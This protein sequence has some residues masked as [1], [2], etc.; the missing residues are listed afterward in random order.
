MDLKKLN[1]TQLLKIKKQVFNKILLDVISIGIT[2]GIFVY[3]MVS[4]G[5][6][7]IYFLSLLIGF[8]IF[9]NSKNDNDLYKEIKKEIR[10]RNL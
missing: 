1:N 6:N 9:K 4:G 3:G 8:L 10:S 7:L 5:F 2:I